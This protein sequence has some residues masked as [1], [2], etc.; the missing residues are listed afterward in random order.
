MSFAY[1]HMQMRVLE[2]NNCALLISCFSLFRIEFIDFYFLL[3]STQTFSVWSQTG[4][5]EGLLTAYQ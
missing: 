3:L 1:L 2:I 4:S 5:V